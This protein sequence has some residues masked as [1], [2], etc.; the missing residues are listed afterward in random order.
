MVTGRIVLV[1]ADCGAMGAKFDGPAEIDVLDSGAAPDTHES[2][3]RL[4]PWGCISSPLEPALCRKLVAN[5]MEMGVCYEEGEN[6]RENLTAWANW[7]VAN[8]R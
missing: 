5:V 6:T 2:L 4:I 3:R 8:L 7:R 1:T